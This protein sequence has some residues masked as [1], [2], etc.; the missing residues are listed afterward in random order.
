MNTIKRDVYVLKNTIKIPIEVTKGTDAI[1]FEFTVRDY[2]LPATA[3]AVAYAYRMGMKKPNSTLCD[4]SGNV[5]S[6]QPSANFFGVG[7]NELQ[8]RVINEDKSLISFK[9]RVKCSDAMGFPDDEEEKQQTLIEQLLSN[10][11]KETEERKKADETERNERTAAIEKEKNERTQADATEKSERKAEID[12][13]RKRID[14]LAKLPAGSTTGDAELKD[15][16]VGADGTIYGNAG[17]AVR[18]QVGLL[19]ED[20]SQLS[21]EISDVYEGI[22]SGV[23]M[24]SFDL[25]DG[26]INSSGEE[27]NN[28]SSTRGIRTSEYIDVEDIY[29]ITIGS[30]LGNAFIIKYDENKNCIKRTSY[31]TGASLKE[32]TIGLQNAKYIRLVLQY[33]SSVS[34]DPNVAAFNSTFLVE[35]KTMFNELVVDVFLFAGQSNMAGRGKTNSTWTETAP[36]VIDGAGFEFRAISDNSKLYP[37]AEPFGVAENNLNG[38]DDEDKKTGSMVSAFTNAYYLHNGGVPIVGIS[39]SKGGSKINQ[40]QPDGAY[41]TDTIARFNDC[42]SFLENSHHVIRHK[43]V[44]WCQGES[45]GDVGT[46][47]EN[48]KSMFQTMLEALLNVGIEKLFM[49]RIG[50]CNAENEFDR[51]SN[52]IKWQNDIAQSNKDVVMVSTAFAGMR[53][54]GLMKDNFHYYQA[55]YNE[56]GSYAGV[57]TAFYVNNGKEPT[58]YDTEYDNL[59]FSKKN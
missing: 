8:I 35:R 10:S 1:T 22:K 13:E 15:I 45:D 36:L 40:W 55:G 24:M 23:I 58:M 25:E 52:V 6:F 5:I 9:E 42:V 16:R 20:L 7:N 18:Q 29:N 57:N 54:R 34:E 14:N 11:G 44:L 46:T 31:N 59:Y 43:Y 51:Y 12:V 4:V 32:G 2:N 41:L 53:E 28:T 33:G 38:I 30:H 21:A 39:A 3:A 50:N 48:Y 37:I 47:E 26:T 17:E 27:T 19:K 56:V 49:V